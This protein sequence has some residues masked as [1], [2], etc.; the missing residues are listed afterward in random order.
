MQDEPLS[1]NVT[2]CERIMSWLTWDSGNVLCFFRLSFIW[3]WRVPQSQISV[4]LINVVISSSPHSSFSA[5]DS[6]L[7]SSRSSGLVPVSKSMVSS[8]WQSDS[9][10]DGQHSPVNN[11]SK[12]CTEMAVQL[13]TLLTLLPRLVTLLFDDLMEITEALCTHDITGALGRVKDNYC[14]LAIISAPSTAQ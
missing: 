12:W 4:Q 6:E 2:K 5:S 14:Q 8:V 10:A 11:G 9:R 1:C 13:S 3:S 7:I